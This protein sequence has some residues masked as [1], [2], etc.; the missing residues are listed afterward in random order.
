MFERFSATGV[1]WADGQPEA[2]DIVL[3]ATGYR[4]HLSYLQGLN[5]LDQ[6]GL[7]LHRAGV[8]TTVEGLYYVGLEQQTNFASATL[9]GVGPDASRVVRHI[10]VRMQQPAGCCRWAMG[11]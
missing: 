4:P 3:F 11:Q 6:A 8:S 10:Q 7:P 5:A 9:R 2:V 1:V